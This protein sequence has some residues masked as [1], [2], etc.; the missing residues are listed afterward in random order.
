MSPTAS[1]PIRGPARAALARGS[2]SA[3]PRLLR[4]SATDRYT[5][6]TLEAPD[7]SCELHTRLQ[8]GDHSKCML[9]ITAHTRARAA[10]TRARP[11]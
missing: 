11:E 4:E 3:P 10:R 6:Q 2:A 5:D 7:R 1:V 8:A 9:D